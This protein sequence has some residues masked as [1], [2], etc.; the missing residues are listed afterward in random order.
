LTGATAPQADA[1]LSLVMH[2]GGTDDIDQE[3]D[4]VLFG[5]DC[6]NY[7]SQQIGLSWDADRNG[8]FETQ[9]NSANFS[10][11]AVDG[12]AKVQVPVEARNPLGGQPGVKN[13]SVTIRNVAPQLSQ[14]AVVDAGGNAIN[15]TVPWA[16][17][18]S[19][20]TV[21]SNFA[22]PGTLDHQ[23]SSISW[24]DGTSDANGTFDEFNEAF[25]DGTGRL[26]DTHIYNSPGTYTLDLTVADDDQD[27]GGTTVDVVVLTP[28]QAVLRLIQMIDTALA[29]TTDA[30]VRAK[31]V[32][33]RIALAGNNQNSQDGALQMI[34]AGNNLAAAAFAETATEWLQRAA[35]DGADVA[36]TITLL[37]QL[38]AALGG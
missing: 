7:Y 2:D 35:E 27:V 8:S 20:I 15:S 6:D 1:D 31:L 29:S 5:S 36:L 12:P 37:Q 18:G 25:G 28:E 3:I 23:T 4:R 19:P 24:G 38:S 26:S 14:F 33:A 22:D 17:T 21:S 11:A 16:L 32:H 30:S 9:G 34:R 10:A 13:A